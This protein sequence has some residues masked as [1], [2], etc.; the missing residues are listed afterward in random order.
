MNINTRKK[1][2][3]NANINLDSIEYDWLGP[4]IMKNT[5]G[6]YITILLVVVIMLTLPG[7]K[8]F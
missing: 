3:S 7:H 4:N 5:R 2:R 1:I 8:S 6:R